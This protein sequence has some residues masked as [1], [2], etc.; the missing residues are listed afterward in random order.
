ML[1]SVRN[2]KGELLQNFGSDRRDVLD[3]RVAY[4]MT[5]MMEAVI[6]SGTAAGVRGM[7]FS[8]PAAGKTGTSH[9]AWFA[10]YTSNLLC[11][12]WVGF[13]DYS[14]LKMSGA[15]T[16]APIWTE[17]M[18]KATA[19]PQYS[20]AQR[21]PAPPGVTGVL[22]DKVTNLRATAK[23][24]ETYTAV[25]ISGTEPQQTCEDSRGLPGMA[26]RLLGI[27]P[28]PLPPVLVSNS[29]QDPEASVRTEGSPPEPEKKKKKKKGFFGR[30][31]G[32]SDDE[33]EEESKPPAPPAPPAKNGT[34]AGKD[35]APA[36][37]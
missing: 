37:H 20:D 19:H 30:I 12:V 28:K 1:N 10:G 16:A 29:P 36:P 6:N 15:N 8:A 24:P 32:G 22:L 21:F 31:F 25:F 7:G 35:P 5:T 17:F 3:P 13:D 26:M 9:D 11:I 23:C 27:D 33:Q 4:V 34:Q 2:A 14:D 18:K